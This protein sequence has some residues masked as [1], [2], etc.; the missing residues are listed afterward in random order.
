MIQQKL[1]ISS[2]EALRGLAMFCIIATHTAPFLRQ[3]KDYDAWYYLGHVIQQLNSFAVP[4][5]FLASGYFFALGVNKHGLPKQIKRYIPRIALLLLIWI[6]LNGVFWGQWLQDVVDSGSLRPLLSNFLFLPQYAVSRPDEFLYWGTAVPLWFLFSLIEGSLVLSILIALKFGTKP[7]LLVGAAAYTFM[8]SASLY[9]DTW[10]GASFTLP[11]Q[12]RGIFIAVFF[13][14][15][16]Y[17]AANSEISKIK[18][19]GLLLLAI[20]IILMFAESAIMSAH[21]DQLFEEHP[22]LFSTPLVAL[23]IFIWAMQNPTAGSNSLL[24][25]IGS[26]SLGIYVV[27]PIVIGA[28]DYY[29]NTTSHPAWELSFPF[30]VLLISMLIVSFLSKIPYLRKAVV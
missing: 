21:N 3:I 16:G 23:S 28:L 6:V 1:K 11:F 10:I 29:G 26:I 13:L 4:F 27:H 15:L 17:F 18:V 25:K 8:L 20:S 19:N 30:L 7:I 12:Q 22:Y 24:F 2:I 5:F 14:S 9:S